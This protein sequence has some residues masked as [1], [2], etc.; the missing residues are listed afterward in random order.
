MRE[1]PFIIPIDHPL[2]IR[3]H[4]RLDLAAKFVVGCFGPVGTVVEGVET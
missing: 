2:F 4:K 3:R 1:L